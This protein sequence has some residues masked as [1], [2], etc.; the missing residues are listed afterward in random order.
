MNTHLVM[1]EIVTSCKEFRIYSLLKS[2]D[3]KQA[4]E[5]ID[6]YLRE[7]GNMDRNFDY[8]ITSVEK[9]DKQE[10]IILEKYLPYL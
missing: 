5:I 10:A 6:E 7:N 4:Q 9:L 8:S 2:R 3:I 1:I